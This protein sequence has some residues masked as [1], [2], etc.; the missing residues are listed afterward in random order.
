[1]KILE[2]KIHNFRQF[3]QDHQL[4]FAISKIKNITLIHGN[5]GS[6]K[7]ALLNAF[8]WLLYGCF[9]EALQAPENVVNIR[10]IKES[11]INN[12]IFCWVQLMFEH[13]N[14]KYRIRRTQVI[15]K[16]DNLNNWETQDDRNLYMQW[17]DE[18]KGE[19]KTEK[20][21]ADVIGRI[22]PKELHRYFFL[23][24]ERIEAL[25][26]PGKKDEVISATKMFIGEE[27]FIRS[28]RHLKNA[29]DKLESE[30]KHLGDR[31]T[32]TLIEEKA[33][34]IE[35]IEDLLKQ[36]ATHDKNKTGYIN[37]IKNIEES[38]RK[39]KDVQELQRRRDELNKQEDELINNQNVARSELSNII[40]N[41]S[42]KI[43]LKG[44]A[45]TFKEIVKDLKK[46][47]ELPSSIKTPFVQELLD[48]GK[49]ICGSD[50][51]E[52]H[53][54]YEKVK[55]WLVK[56]GISSIEEK[57]IRMEAEIGQL[58][59]DI[60]SIYERI[61]REQNAF[62]QCKDQISKI[63]EELE[64]IS[65]QL[66]NSKEENI[67]ELEAKKEDAEKRCD[68]EKGDIVLKK[69][70][71][72][73]KY[74]RVEDI[75]NEINKRKSINSRHELAKRRFDACNQ[76]IK[77]IEE[78]QL[79]LRE[80]FRQDLDGRVKKIFTEISFKPYVPLLDS[81][82]SLKLMENEGSSIVVGASTGENQ[83]LSLAFIGAIIEQA[84]QFSMERDRLPGPD[85]SHFPIVLDSSFG[86]LDPIYR[87]HIA[88]KIPLIAD[89]VILLLSKAQ[90]Q[91]EVDAAT[92]RKIGKEYVIEYHSPKTD[93]EEAKIEL[94]GRVYDLVKKTTEENEY[95]EIIEVI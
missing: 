88:T 63:Q 64:G 27:I 46:R 51:I 15:K 35:E 14:K 45:N 47:G 52:G 39:Q 84:R 93:A 20:Y 43:Y 68:A 61:S 3:Y 74:K 42:Y 10:A 18:N 53:D 66:K 38:L 95:V 12:E 89:Q 78:V 57:A 48:R 81:D 58:E 49:C 13:N 2:L 5:N 73:T 37:L 8:T 50:L 4:E 9:T 86:N 85:N 56:S 28:I 26:R 90:W 30:L 91:G 31:E 32:K 82:Y 65:G 69:D 67:R 36:I 94:R 23:D 22:L 33:K 62:S 34:L 6:G 92:N 17:A 59:Q 29:G 24:G 19:W 75:K 21:A 54:C 80:N 7:T 44:A 40:S 16:I 55:E 70:Q 60:P 87:R 83:I 1:M 11:D 71:I 72:N 79:R 77:I 41:F 25:Q 76:S